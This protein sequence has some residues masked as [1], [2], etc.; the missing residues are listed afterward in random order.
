[1]GEYGIAPNE[2]KANAVLIA[3]VPEMYDMLLDCAEFLEE[4]EMLKCEGCS[5]YAGELNERLEALLMSIERMEIEN[6]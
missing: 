6:Y 4:R 3:H 5:E 2:A 1:M